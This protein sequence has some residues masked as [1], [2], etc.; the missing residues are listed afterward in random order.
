MTNNLTQALD[1]AA[2]GWY[3]FACK[4]DKT[5]ATQHGMKDA[6]TDPAQIKAWWKRQPDAL[7]GIYCERS[8]LFALDVD[9]KTADGWRSLAELQAQHGGEDIPVGP[10]QQTPSGGAHLIFKLPPDVKIPNNANKLAPAL[11]LRSNG[12][13][14]TGGAYAWYPDHGPDAQLT[15]AP[16]WLLELIKNLKPAPKTQPKAVAVAPDTGAWWLRYYLDRATPGNRNDC[17]FSL[18]CQLRDS[19]LAR[20]EAESIMA[21]YAAGVPGDGYTEREALLSLQSAFQGGKREAAHLPGLAAVNCDLHKRNDERNNGNKPEKTPELEPFTDDQGAT[22]ADIAGVLGPITWAWPKWVANGMLHIVASEP[23]KGKSILCLRL[24]ACYLMGKTWP[25][26]TE[27]TGE[28]GKVLWCEAEAGQAVNLERAKNWG[29]PLADLLTPLGNPL[30]DLRLDNAS[31]IRALEAMARRDDVKLIILDSLRGLHTRDE[32]SSE[33]MSVVHWLAEL[34]RDIQKPVILTHHLR[35]RGL[36]D[37]GEAP[38]LDRLRGSTAITQAARLV[39]ALDNPDPMQE[40]IARLSVIKSNL[41][42]FPEPVGMIISDHGA[43]FTHAPEAPKTESVADKA[44][45]LLLAMLSDEPKPAGEI[46]TELQSAGVSWRSGKRAKA[47]LGIVSIKRED[48]RWYWSLPAKRE[49]D[50]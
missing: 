30:E 33:V 20:A 31:H 1:H 18:A 46:E 13:I 11:D 9:V 3:V 27:F 35:K 32:N 45:D 44:A 24:A 7:I 41:A 37:I 26:G 36:F 2:R 38:N 15:E 22:W 10:I 21:T 48:G 29:L 12:Y 40:H 42:K 23:G 6:T 39:W 19:G 14:C 17:G 4:S 43:T 34:A 25:D 49:Y 5:P 8:G 50:N 16:D 47:R 28:L